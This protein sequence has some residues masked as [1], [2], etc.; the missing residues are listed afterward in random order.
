MKQRW[1][2]E[3]HDNSANNKV[4]TSLYQNDN[5]V[6]NKAIAFKKSVTQSNT[7]NFKHTSSNVVCETH[8]HDFWSWFDQNALLKYPQD[9]CV[10]YR[11]Y[12]HNPYHDSFANSFEEWNKLTA[13]EQELCLSVVDGYVSLRCNPKQRHNT[14]RYLQQKIF[15]ISA[16]HT[17]AI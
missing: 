15:Q 13:K 8:T 2:N 1:G 4:I 11:K 12:G 5:E 6:D 3:K 7:L 17:V 10:W 9:F 16:L 14:W